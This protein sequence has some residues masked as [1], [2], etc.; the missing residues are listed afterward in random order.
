VQMVPTKVNNRKWIDEFI[1]D[2]DALYL[3]DRGYYNY[4]WYDKLTNDGNKF[5]IRQINNA[6][7]EEIKSTYVE[8]D[9]V[10]IVKLY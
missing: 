7:V 2:K 6:M 5:I 10:L 4:T 8:N 1:N 9:L 3:F